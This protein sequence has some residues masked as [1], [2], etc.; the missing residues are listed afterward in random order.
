MGRRNTILEGGREERRRGGIERRIGNRKAEKTSEWS[1]G[2][3]MKEKWAHE[4]MRDKDR[5]GELAS[6]QTAG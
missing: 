4:D 6:V 1:R 3:S 2:V 5:K